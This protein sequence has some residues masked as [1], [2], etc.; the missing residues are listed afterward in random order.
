ML[1]YSVYNKQFTVTKRQKLFSN[2][3]AMQEHV[4][5]TYLNTIENAVYVFDFIFTSNYWEAAI[6]IILITTN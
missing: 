2:N 6:I 5:G 1:F 4:Y 3:K